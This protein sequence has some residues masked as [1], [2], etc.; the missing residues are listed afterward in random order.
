MDVEYEHDF[1]GAT[2][3]IDKASDKL[4]FV[5]GLRVTDET[6]TL[7]SFIRSGSGVDLPGEGRI[8][9][10][11]TEA[12]LEDGTHYPFYVP[13]KRHEACNWD[14]PE[15]RPPFD[16]CVHPQRDFNDG[17]ENGVIFRV[18]DQGQG[19]EGATANGDGFLEA[20]YAL[21]PL[22]EWLWLRRDSY[23]STGL[24]DRGFT[25]TPSGGRPVG[26]NPMEPLFIPRALD[27]DEDKTFGKTPF[28]WLVQ[29]TRSNT[30]Q[31]FVDPAWT[32]LQR[33][34]FPQDVSW[35]SQYCYN[36]FLGDDVQNGTCPDR[37][38]Q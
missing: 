33:Y 19:L 31:W 13:A 14:D 15:V 32:F 2:F 30:G 26:Q 35:S 36:L 17:K 24:F 8:T 23:G 7:I 4:L 5:E 34:S 37:S 12:Q 9:G 16:T 25:Y 10:S 38:M 22:A 20:S 28:Q 21:L 1:T 18:G 11:F 29:P 3:I 6:D 27:T